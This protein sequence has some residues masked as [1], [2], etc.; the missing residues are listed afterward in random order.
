MKRQ[1]IALALLLLA[2]TGTASAVQAALPPGT[3]A[4]DFTLPT[5]KDS[6]LTLTQFRGQVIILAFW[7]SN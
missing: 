4:P 5:T 3:A 2:L 6:T 1:Q 7:K